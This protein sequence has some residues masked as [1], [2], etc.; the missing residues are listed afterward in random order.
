MHNLTG[1]SIG[2]S[3]STM[4]SDD[5]KKILSK[6]RIVLLSLFL[7]LFLAM[8]PAADVMAKSFSITDYPN[9][10]NYRKG[11]KM[12]INDTVT[13]TVTSQ[14]KIPGDGV[15]LRI[16]PLNQDGTQL[17]GWDQRIYSEQINQTDDFPKSVTAHIPIDLPSFLDRPYTEL[18]HFSVWVINNR[19]G[20]LIVYIKPVFVDD[21]KDAEEPEESEKEPEEEEETKT[22]YNPDAINA[23]YYVNGVLQSNAVIGKQAQSPVAASIFAAS[24][25]KG[26]RSAF[27]MSMSYN[28][29]NEY[30]LKNGTIVLYVP[31]AFQKSGRQYAILAMGRNG[32]VVLCPDTDR[33]QNTVTVTPGVEGYAYELI[34]KD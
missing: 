9:N 15:C 22:I 7:G 24:L 29:K 25:P 31:E 34:Y 4:V 10:E 13:W 17:A 18:D 30:S 16:I 3:N 2:N 28:G 26:W 23:G 6:G 5:D 1:S 14:D 11:T 27:S 21:I 12:Y 32:N 8:I 33:I 19:D 20:D